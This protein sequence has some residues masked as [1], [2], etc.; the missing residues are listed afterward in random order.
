MNSFKNSNR[1]PLWLQYTLTGSCSSTRAAFAR[2]DEL[3]REYGFNVFI[4]RIARKLPLV[5]TLQRSLLFLLLLLRLLMPLLPVMLWIGQI[6]VPSNEFTETYTLS[7][8]HY[9]IY[10]ALHIYVQK[11]SN[12][13]CLYNACVHGYINVVHITQLYSFSHLA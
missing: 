8:L 7:L 3:K 6:F 4:C 1:P 11:P 10:I 12:T 2:R 5:C 9:T 13:H